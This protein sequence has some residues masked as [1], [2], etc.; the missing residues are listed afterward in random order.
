MT[1]ESLPIGHF[2]ANEY[3][4]EKVLGQGGF[5]ITYKVIDELDRELVIKEYFPKTLAQRAT[6]KITVEPAEAGQQRINPNDIDSK[7]LYTW[8]ADKFYNEARIISRI[9]GNGTNP[10]IVQISRFFRCNG[11]AYFVMDYRKGKTLEDRL[12]QKGTLDE[13]EVLFLTKQILE[14]LKTVH[15]NNY[16]HGDIKP[17]NLYLYDN[18]NK[19]MLIDFGIA[20][21]ETSTYTQGI[22]CYSKGYSAPEQE[23]PT[24]N[25]NNL[26]DIR[27][28]LYSVGAVMY[29]C[30]TGKKPIKAPDEI[31]KD[32]LISAH[33]P[34]TKKQNSKRRYSKH[35]LN[36]IDQALC[37]EPDQRFQSVH[38]M[39][40]ALK[41][42]RYS[43][44]LINISLLLLFII[45]FITAA[46]FTHPFD[47]IDLKSL[48][49]NPL[50]PPE[51]IPLESAALNK[52]PEGYKQHHIPQ[53][54][55][56]ITIESGCFSLG[57]SGENTQ[58]DSNKEICLKRFA[59]SKYEISVG[60]FKQ[61]VEE[62]KYKTSAED[63]NSS[64][65]GCYQWG[66]SGGEYLAHINWHHPG[67]EQNDDYPVVCVTFQDALA[68]TTW[69]QKTTN[70][71]FRLPTEAEWEYAARAGTQARYFWGDSTDQVKI[72]A[73]SYIMGEPLPEHPMKR[74]GF[75][76]N[77]WGIFD[78]LGN[79]SEW[80]CSRHT[81]PL[82]KE[83]TSKNTCIDKPASQDAHSISDSKLQV[84]VRGG[85]WA[86]RDLS[87]SARSGQSLYIP[88]NS[89]GFRI[90]EDL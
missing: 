68:Y 9:N 38:E 36:V 11:T 22:R 88:L 20:R 63:G 62:E 43:H 80:T 58:S 39:A 86:S 69:L 8:G 37:L 16:I 25:E 70:R 49:S 76:P 4:I 54:P 26:S 50:E 57:T 55:E 85:F 59:I 78:I 12:K 61:F 34:Y 42:R 83:D 17:A 81:T 46:F 19:V 40:E 14:G 27:S 1:S 60:E 2:L 77:Q 56:M 29:R 48:Q 33:T 72:Y 18:D 67:F 31:E 23:D 51:T 87:I 41:S 65:E 6:D 10:N 13:Q 47:F 89:I 7:N 32:K 52:E 3:R 45:I 74:G 15:E 24:H 71:A 66:K 53:L 79:V 73:H 21:H 75:K 28:D 5:A 84:T 82:E 35:L 30:V 64:S 44:K 90:A